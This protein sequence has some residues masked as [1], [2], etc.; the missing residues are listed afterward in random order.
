MI[1]N[2]IEFHNVDHLEKTESMDGKKLCRFPKEVSARL[3]TTRN[4]NGRFR[5]NHPHGCELRFVTGAPYFEITLTAMEQDTEVL[6]YRGDLFHQRHMLRAG[7]RTLLH[8]DYP[9]IYGSVE[10]EK[11]EGRRFAPWV[12]RVQFG[13][14]GCVYF[15]DLDTCG[16][17][18][19]PPQRAE[20]P[21][22][23]WA[24]Y[25]SSITCGCV[26]NVYSSSYI[27]QAA[28]ALGWDVLNKGLSGSCLC[29][30]EAAEYLAELDVDAVSLEV[31]VNMVMFFDEKETQ[32]R[33]EYLLEALHK[34][35]AKRIF[36]LDMFPNKGL[37]ALDE[38]SDYYRHY[39]SFK[40]IV[41]QAVRNVE[42]D[43]FYLIHGEEV[44]KDLTYL[45]T[46]LLHPSDDGHVRMG[47]NLAEL[48]RACGEDRR[49]RYPEE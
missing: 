12:W 42:D 40:E 11:L 44:L 7:V 13:L 45:S 14:N 15:H 35:P 30:P 36:V 39:R 18:R 3:G 27:N 5:A 8:V 38:Q 21:K 9:A 10:E 48:F 20:K 4:Y 22:T 46:D 26:T 17:D 49:G 32:K 2:G 47:R 19:R 16:F 33:V 23:R 41:R 28:I 29:E 6:I 24:A 31:G 25:G 43:R 37:I 1:M 34:S